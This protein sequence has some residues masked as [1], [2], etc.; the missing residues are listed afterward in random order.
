MSDL[1][2]PEVLPQGGPE[3]R[4]MAAWN[5]VAAP[6]PGEGVRSQH[7]G[8]I[9]RCVASADSSL[10]DTKEADIYTR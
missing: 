5:F 6:V 8:T 1:P 9:P 10:A 2:P 4:E 7:F 3:W